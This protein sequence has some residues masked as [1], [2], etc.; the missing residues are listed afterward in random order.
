MKKH[1]QTIKRKITA[2]ITVFIDVDVPDHIVEYAAIVPELNSF[3]T[4]VLILNEIRVVA[5]KTK[6]KDLI[7]KS[8]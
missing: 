4:E 8:E 7:A 1:C 3:L 2:E 6:I 5:I